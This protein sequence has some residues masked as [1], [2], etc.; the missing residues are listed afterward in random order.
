MQVVIILSIL[1]D[2]STDLRILM[3]L[4]SAFLAN[5]VTIPLDMYLSITYSRI[6]PFIFKFIFIDGLLY[7]TQLYWKP[8]TPNEKS[9]MVSAL[10][11]NLQ[12][13]RGDGY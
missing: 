4:K 9:E 10:R 7:A 2:E 1:D 11:K 3:M 13:G 6:H 5:A 12:S 8:I